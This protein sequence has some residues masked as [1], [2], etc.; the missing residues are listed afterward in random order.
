MQKA[1][2]GANIKLAEVVSD[3]TGVSARAMLEAL[4]GGQTDPE[5]LAEL[6]V[7]QLRTKREVLERALTGEVRAHQCFMIAQHLRLI[8][9]FDAQIAELTAE[10]GQRLAPFETQVTLLDGIP[11][12]GRWTAEGILAEIGTDMSRFPSAG[13]LGSGR[14]CVRVTRKAAG[15]QT[16]G[17]IRKGSPWLKVLLTEAA[18]AA[19]RSKATYLSEIYHILIARRGKKKTAIAVGRMILEACYRVL[20]TGQ[21]YDEIRLRRMR[22]SP[23]KSSWCVNSKNS[24][25]GSPWNPLHKEAICTT[26]PQLFT[27]AKSNGL[28]PSSASQRLCSVSPWFRPGSSPRPTF[29]TR[30][31]G[32]KSMHSPRIF[33]APSISPR[34][35]KNSRHVT[36]ICPPTNDNAQ[37]SQSPST[38]SR[39]QPRR[40]F[41]L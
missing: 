9:A 40:G 3:V 41:V 31:T 8:D 34:I 2:E 4:V 28:L 26:T 25:I 36:Q 7:R 39:P 14:R 15:K 18:N 6:A 10:I 38:P 32:A 33:F 37:N 5:A 12:I 29:V 21:P 30:P 13:H 24:G 27:A 23:P 16:S 17:R 1:L 35:T 22:R 11:G 20:S 19:G